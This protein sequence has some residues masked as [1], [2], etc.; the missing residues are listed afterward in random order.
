[1]LTIIAEIQIRSGAKHYEN[2]CH[3]FKK[4]TPIVLL[5]KGC[6]GYELLTD[7]L[8]EVDFQTKVPDSITLLEHWESM[9]HL[10]AHLKTA[11]MQAYQV[12]VKDDVIGVKIRIMQKGLHI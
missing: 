2:V 5:E 11:H 6:Y 3:A 10:K 12:Q 8:T 4:I 7:Y 1:M 9:Q